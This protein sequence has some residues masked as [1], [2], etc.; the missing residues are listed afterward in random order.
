MEKS[1][2]LDFYN[3]P[4]TQKEN[5]GSPNKKIQWVFY[6]MAKDYNQNNI[7]SPSHSIL[8]VLF[9]GVTNEIFLT[10]IFF[11]F[12]IQTS[13]PRI[14]SQ[15]KSLIMLVNYWKVMKTEG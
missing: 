1:F 4:H 13:S 7:R 10:I 9:E 3:L 15:M 2:V 14:H 5:H 8:F 11:V 6:E 12:R